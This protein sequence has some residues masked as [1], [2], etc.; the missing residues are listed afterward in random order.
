LGKRGRDVDALQE[1]S[2]RFTLAMVHSPEFYS[3]AAEAG[4]DLYLCGHTHAGQVCLPG[5]RAVITHLH[6]GK[7]YLQGLWKYRGMTGFTNSG[8]GCSGLPVR[9]FTRPEIAVLTLRTVGS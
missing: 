1:A 3:Q 6:R 9:F 5:G 7:R 8:A 4:V 2:D